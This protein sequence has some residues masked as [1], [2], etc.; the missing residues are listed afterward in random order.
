MTRVIMASVGMAATPQEMFLRERYLEVSGL[1]LCLEDKG[2]PNN[3]QIRSISNRKQFRLYIV[4]Q[5]NFFFIFAFVFCLVNFK[6]R[7]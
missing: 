2:Q 7:K 4:N 5:I 6:E 1:L 3:H